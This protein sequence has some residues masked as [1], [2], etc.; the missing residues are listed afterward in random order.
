MHNDKSSNYRSI[1]PKVKQGTSIL[2]MREVMDG[3]KLE[4]ATFPESFQS[5]ENYTFKGGYPLPRKEKLDM[6]M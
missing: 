3:K 2:T 1:P 4:E 6:E 5:F